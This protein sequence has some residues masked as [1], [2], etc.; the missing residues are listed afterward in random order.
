MEVQAVLGDGLARGRL[1]VDRQRDGAGEG[2]EVDAGA[3]AQGRDDRR[4]VD[5]D[6]DA[7]ELVERPPRE[8]RPG[9]RSGEVGD[10]GVR[11]AARRGDGARRL[12]QLVLGAGGHG[13]A[14]AA[15]RE[16]QRDGAADAATTAGDQGGLVVQMVHGLVLC[17]RGAALTP[18]DHPATMPSPPTAHGTV[19]E[20]TRVSVPPELAA[21]STVPESVATVPSSASGSPGASRTSDGVPLPAFDACRVSPTRTIQHVA[22]SPVAIDDT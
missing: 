14:G 22:A 7:T 4:V 9:A 18:V 17:R 6:V 5:E 20:P 8:R 16:L 2:L 21:A 1:V 3:G 10:D 19:T 15:L 12:D 11:A 13:D